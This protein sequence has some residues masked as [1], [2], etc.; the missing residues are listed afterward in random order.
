MRVTKT[1]AAIVARLAALGGREAYGLQLVRESGGA[2]K[3][4]SIYVLLGRL[5][6]KGLV[7]SRREDQ[8]HLGGLIPRVLYRITPA[9][10]TAYNAWVSYEK[11]LASITPSAA[12]PRS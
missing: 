10:L 1:E 5:E 11:A 2:L 9:G 7:Q 12:A 6:D 4:G 3:T 8:N